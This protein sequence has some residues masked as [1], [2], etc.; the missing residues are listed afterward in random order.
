M[1]VHQLPLV[2]QGILPLYLEV[3][4]WIWIKGVLVLIVTQPKHNSVQEPRAAVVRRR[5]CDNP[6]YVVL[7]SLEERI[8]L[9]AQS[10]APPLA[11]VQPCWRC[12]CCNQWWGWGCLGSQQDALSLTSGRHPNC[13]WVSYD[14]SR[15][16]CW[17]MSGD[18]KGVEWPGEGGVGSCCKSQDSTPSPL[19]RLCSSLSLPWNCPS[20]HS[21]HIFNTILPVL[22]EASAAVAGYD[23][24]LPIGGSD[25]AVSDSSP[26]S[27]T[28]VM[29]AQG[30]RRIGL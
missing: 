22:E 24:L 16:F 2:F 4:F 30:N 28:Q 14:I 7:S 3:K 29:A 15:P 5:K 17:H 11:S 6:V 10:Y 19:P 20:P 13:L 21:E 23:T 12:A 1:V 18:T 25:P 9:T 26:A 8:Q 27:W